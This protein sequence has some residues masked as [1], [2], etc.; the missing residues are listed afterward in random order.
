MRCSPLNAALC[1]RQS[2]GA[3]SV[4]VFGCLYVVRL[5]GVKSLLV[6]VLRNGCFSLKR[7]SESLVSQN[8]LRALNG[9]FL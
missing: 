4:V 9:R 8:V 6:T 5:A 3:Y 7:C 2:F 1:G